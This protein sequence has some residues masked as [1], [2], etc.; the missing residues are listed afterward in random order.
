MSTVRPIYL[1]PG[2]HLIHPTP[3]KQIKDHLSESIRKV[4]IILDE[5]KDEY[6]LDLVFDLSQRL[7]D[8]K[9]IIDEIK[10][11]P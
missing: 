10:Y 8:I 1:V 9:S 7:L 6:I 5:S 3:Y 11:Y 4:G 2:T